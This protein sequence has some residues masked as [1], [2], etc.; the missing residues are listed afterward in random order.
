LIIHAAVVAKGNKAILLPAPQGSGKSTLCAALV[1]SGWRLF[2]DEL[3]IISLKDASVFPCVRP[4]SLKNESI[5]IIKSRFPDARL[6][7]SVHDTTKGTVSLMMPGLES[8]KQG[9]CPAKISAIVFP[10]YQL[11]VNGKFEVKDKSQTFI[12][13][14]QNSFNYH[15]IS[16]QSFNIAG[17]I[18]ESAYCY[19]YIYSDL[20]KAILDFD[21]LV[22]LD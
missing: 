14:I 15:V 5:N 10:K 11:E 2:S 18:V 21:S 8:V 3:A 1:N 17:D 16:N 6:M 12:E 4:V 22:D 7:P 19:E 9:N 13:L 20:T